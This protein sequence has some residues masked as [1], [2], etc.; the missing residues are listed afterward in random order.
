MNRGN[1]DAGDATVSIVSSTRRPATPDC[2][3]L[4]LRENQQAARPWRS[5]SVVAAATTGGD[6]ALIRAIGDDTNYVE[7]MERAATHIPAD[8]AR[9]AIIFFTDGRHD[10]A[11]VPVSEVIPAK[12]RLFGTRSPFALLP[13]GMG[14]DPDDRPRLEAGLANLRITRD[15]ERCEGGALDWPAVVFETAEAAGRRPLPSRT[16]LHVHV[17]PTPLRPRRRPRA[18]GTRR[19]RLRSR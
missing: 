14:V 11:G 10:V 17:R 15:F 6:R 5:A 2:T 19:Q 13:V 4:Q 9:P 18:A 8:A 12:D 7:A 3:G 1:D 16:S